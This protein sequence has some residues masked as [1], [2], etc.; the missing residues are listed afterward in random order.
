M[1]NYSFKMTKQF[2]FS[3]KILP[4]HFCEQELTVI[5]HVIGQ[6]LTLNTKLY[7][8]KNDDSSL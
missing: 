3:I 6:I 8:T 4:S 2:C 1:S 5:S 7:P